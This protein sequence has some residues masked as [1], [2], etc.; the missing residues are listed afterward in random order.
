[1]NG[2]QSMR[3]LTRLYRRFRPAYGKHC[4][5]DVTTLHFPLVISCGRSVVGGHLCAEHQAIADRYGLAWRGWRIALGR[6]PDIRVDGETFAAA[7]VR[8]YAHLSRLEPDAFSDPTVAQHVATIN[9][10]ETPEGAI[11]AA[12]EIAADCDRHFE[13]NYEVAK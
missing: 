5:W 4:T 6:I 8:W 9:G 12:R 13:E 3:T 1:M 11:A 10:D 2:D 7:D